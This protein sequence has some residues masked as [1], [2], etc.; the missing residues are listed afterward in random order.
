[1]PTTVP[2]S[3]FPGFVLTTATFNVLPEMVEPFVVIKLETITARAF[4]FA[5]GAG[6]D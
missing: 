2:V 6:F 1:M 4:E 5:E 3:A